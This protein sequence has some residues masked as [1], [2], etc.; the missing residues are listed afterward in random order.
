MGVGVQKG[1]NLKGAS[2]GGPVRAVDPTP[3]SRRFTWKRFATA[4]AA[5][6]TGVVAFGNG[7]IDFL[8]KMTTAD[9][10]ARIV[11]ASLQ[12]PRFD[13]VQLRISNP[14]SK[15]DSLSEPAFECVTEDDQRVA[16]RYVWYEPLG[17]SPFPGFPSGS[18]FPLNVAANSTIE[19][20][21]LVSRAGGFQGLHDCRE[22]RFSWLDT[23]HRR[24]HGPA[25][26]IPPMTP[27]IVFMS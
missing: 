17:D 16:L 25:V 12:D 14:S 2:R 8:T 27:F 1:K 10:D 5:I 20:S 21:V 19:T 15:G 22:L 9:I 13:L 6:C 18:R 3:G 4:T 11:K 24:Q 23:H 26:K 7:S